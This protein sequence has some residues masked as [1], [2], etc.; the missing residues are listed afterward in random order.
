MAGALRSLR[1]AMA[2][3]GLSGLALD[4]ASGAVLAAVLLSAMPFLG[5]L[6]DRARWYAA[7]AISS[8]FG[9]RAS[10]F[11]MNYATFPGVI[12]HELAHAFVA[13]L[14][15]CRINEI[16]MFEPSGDSLGHVKFTCQGSRR[17]QS[18]QMAASSCAPVLC[19]MALVPG[20]WRLASMFHGALLQ[21]MLFHFS[22]S[23]ACHMTMSRA[24]MASY[25][26]GAIGLF[27]RM[28]PVCL[29]VSYAVGRG[30]IGG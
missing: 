15:G 28:A 13:R 2:A 6:V 8:M 11:V 26:K 3:Y 25:R 17:R 29:C 30:S 27:I 7:R 18:F 16:R 10:F 12:A 22:I 9:P 5:F 19:G 4:A 14:S 24:D 21:A 20:I 1:D 23:V